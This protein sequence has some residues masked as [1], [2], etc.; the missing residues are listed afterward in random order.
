MTTRSPEIN[1]DIPQGEKP[2]GSQTEL[3]KQK[4]MEMQSAIKQ[5]NEKARFMDTK[6]VNLK[7]WQKVINE[8]VAGINAEL[9]KSVDGA[10]AKID[11]LLTEMYGRGD[12]TGVD[13]TGK[14]Q[15]S[16]ID[17]LN[18]KN[19]SSEYQSKALDFSSDKGGDFAYITL[20]PDFYGQ[21]PTVT[22]ACIY[23][24][25]WVHQPQGGFRFPLFL[26]PGTSAEFVMNDKNGKRHVMRFSRNE[27]GEYKKE[28]G[29]NVNG[30][31]SADELIA[32]EEQ[33]GRA[34]RL[35]DD[36]YQGIEDSI[37]KPIQQAAERNK[38]RIATAKRLYDTFIFKLSEPN[39]LPDMN[40]LAILNQ[41]IQGLSADQLQAAGI[42]TK[43]IVL[44]SD[45]NKAVVYEK[46]QFRIGDSSQERERIRNFDN[47]TFDAFKYRSRTENYIKSL[48]NGIDFYQGRQDSQ[49][50][51][52]SP[53][54]RQYEQSCQSTLDAYQ[55]FS[56]EMIKIKASENGSRVDI[57]SQGACGR[58]FE[59]YAKS[60]RTLSNNVE[61]IYMAAYEKDANS[62]L[63]QELQYQRDQIQ[64]ELVKPY[65]QYFDAY[66][67]ITT[68]KKAQVD[69]K[70]VPNSRP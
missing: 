51:D 62:Q 54:Y 33:K 44:S 68:E 38:E 25:Q 35:R 13:S 15:A 60:V 20:G 42:S 32:K 18:K 53:L 7:A 40:R 19:E 59:Q 29:L 8:R 31:K 14:K 61:K 58:A 24:Y 47:Y 56:A 39:S 66:D 12:G 3:L 52:Q 67:K 16:L 4:H 28:D 57:Y 36:I 37:N 34:A 65:Q 46:G 23:Q 30:L 55:K 9:T 41:N 45:P 26:Q 22:G 21:C 1:P 2:A 69:K 50:F 10:I 63:S 43:E 49:Y 48:K 6:D 27:K 11:E 64:E 70:E 17:F 5:F